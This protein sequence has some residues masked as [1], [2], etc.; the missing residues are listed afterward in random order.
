MNVCEGHQ[1]Y[2]K[3][4]KMQKIIKTSSKNIKSKPAVLR[5]ESVVSPK[6]PSLEKS[7]N[8]ARDSRLPAPGSTIIKTYRSK[9]IEVKVLENGF[10]YDGKIFKSISRVAMSIVK[11]QIS[12]YVFFGL[13]K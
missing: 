6:T 5:V 7:L 4:R 12:G 1:P 8:K 3:E 2:S 13:N 10:E 11:R 9:I